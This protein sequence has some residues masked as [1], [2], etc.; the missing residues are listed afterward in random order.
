[1]PYIF[2]F[3]VIGTFALVCKPS[4]P[5]KAREAAAESEPPAL[6]VKQPPESSELRLAPNQCRLVGTV[7]AIDSTFTTA[8]PDDPCAKAPC[9]ATVRIET[10]LGYG[11]AFLRPLANGEEIPVT[12]MFTLAPTQDLVANLSRSY[13]GLRLGAKFLADVEAR[14]APAIGESGSTAFVI[15]GYELK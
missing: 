8:D 11:P 9:R 10:V 7:V 2:F 14:E 1:M 15:Y 12:F 5:E 13:P 6:S 4:P 3:A